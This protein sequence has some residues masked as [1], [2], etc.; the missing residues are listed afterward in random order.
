MGSTELAEAWWSELCEGSNNNLRSKYPVQNKI[1]QLKLGFSVSLDFFY[2]KLKW[3]TA[4]RLAC[5]WVQDLTALLGI[6]EHL[7]SLW[8]STAACMCR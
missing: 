5:I 4:G 8:L 6:T 7:C 3:Q 2:I 1:I